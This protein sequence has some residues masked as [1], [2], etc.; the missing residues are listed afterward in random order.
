MEIRES[1]VQFIDAIKG[2]TLY[3]EYNRQKEII[4]Q[5]PDLKERID[6][7][8]ERNFQLQNSLEGLEL[9]EQVEKLNQEYEET[10]SNP[11]VSDFLAAELA[12]CRMMQEINHQVAESL[13]FE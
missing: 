5:H 7:F 10:R 11:L 3:Q 6:E 13:D 12:F 9:L 4:K 2:S 8:R 1:V